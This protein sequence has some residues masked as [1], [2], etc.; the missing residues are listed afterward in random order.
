MIPAYKPFLLLIIAICFSSWSTP[1]KNLPRTN[2]PVEY[3]NGEGVKLSRR[4]ECFHPV[5]AEAVYTVTLCADVPDNDH[6][7]K[8]YYKKEPGHV[9][10]IVEKKDS[11]SQNNSLAQVFGFYP[12][13]PVS[14][15]VFKNVRCEILDNGEREYN[16]A[17]TKEISADEFQLLLDQAEVLTR[18]KYNI[19]RFNCY[20]YALAVFNSLP[21]IEKLPVTHVKFPFIFGRGGSPCGLYKDLE[22]L[23]ADSG[24]WAPYIKFGLFKAPASYKK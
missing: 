17:I 6:P 5:K 7:S 18:K 11:A 22:K 24:A 20:D 3:V 16:V 10:L 14:S 4:F 13:R 23:K 1:V 21:G 2:H 12:R 19:N 15:I 9:F 8:V